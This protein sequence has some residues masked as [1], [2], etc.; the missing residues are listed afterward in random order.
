MSDESDNSEDDSVSESSESSEL[1]EKVTYMQKLSE[2]LES[3]DVRHT[4]FSNVDLLRVNTYS[5]YSQNNHA[6]QALPNNDF[7]PRSAIVTDC[8][9]SNGPNWHYDEPH[10]VIK[11]ED[12]EV[13]NIELVDSVTIRDES[14]YR[15]YYGDD[16]IGHLINTLYIKYDYIKASAYANLRDEG[17]LPDFD[18]ILSYDDFYPV[19]VKNIIIKNAGVKLVMNVPIVNVNASSGA[20]TAFREIKYIAHGTYKDSGR[21]DLYRYANETGELF[22]LLIDPQ[23]KK[24][25]LVSK[26]QIIEL[27]DAADFKV[28]N[29]DGLYN[30]YELK[31]SINKITDEYVYVYD[32][33]FF[34]YWL[35]VIKDVR[36]PNSGKLTKPAAIMW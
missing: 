31:D 23:T 3:F 6:M 27:I 16:Y 26:T 17:V 30:G 36:K 8:Y 34:T 9:Y 32:N 25:T 13:I 28:Y 12:D 4:Y 1:S 35:S 7:D 21:T 22:A 11:C 10:I 18:D 29:K 33:I 2:I 19:D 20:I 14:Y 5:T 15:I 24:P